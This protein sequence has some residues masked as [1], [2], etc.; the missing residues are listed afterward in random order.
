M[1]FGAYTAKFI[2]GLKNR[3]ERRIMKA[4]LDDKHW[5]EIEGGSNSANATYV[6]DFLC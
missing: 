4:L 5:E 2:Q 6:Y 3:N 1:D